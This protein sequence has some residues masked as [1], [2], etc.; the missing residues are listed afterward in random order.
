MFLV[1]SLLCYK[2]HESNFVFKK[3]LSNTLL[4]INLILHMG[5][6]KKKLVYLTMGKQIQWHYLVTETT[7][8]ILTFTGVQAIA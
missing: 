3:K 1:S 8:P 7:H 5:R 6:L 2:K 4:N